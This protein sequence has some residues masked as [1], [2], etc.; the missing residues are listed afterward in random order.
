M[1]L[2]EVIIL[3][4]IVVF[5]LIT[6]L[7][8][9]YYLPFQKNVNIFGDTLSFYLTYNQGAAGGQAAYIIGDNNNNVTIIL[10]CVSGLILLSYFFYIRGKK[11][12]TTY[13]VLIGVAIYLALSLS[14]ELTQR[15]FIDV[16]VSSWT[17]SVI[18]KLTG[19]TLYGSLFF[20]TKNKWIRISAL[21]ILACGLGNLI[22]H[23][24]LP[25]RVIDFLN[26]E[27]S[28]DLLRI[29]V[30]NFADLA[31]YMGAIGLILSILY[32]LLKKLLTHTSKAVQT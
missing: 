1:K 9:N 31:F 11:I 15:L 30:F 32:L 19:L 24:Y 25:Y 18:G 7:T 23:F 8:A 10:T 12:R 21:I 17:T 29:G 28:Y 14:L 13:K 20:L 3:F 26:I 6:K 4:T 2:K 22:S 16:A 5:D 27:G